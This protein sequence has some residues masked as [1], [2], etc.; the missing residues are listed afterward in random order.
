[1]QRIL[2]FLLSLVCFSSY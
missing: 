1:M 2:N